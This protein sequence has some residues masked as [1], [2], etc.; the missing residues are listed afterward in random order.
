M[1]RIL[2]PGL[3]S[4]NGKTTAYALNRKAGLSATENWMQRGAQKGRRAGA[5][6]AAK[7][8]RAALLHRYRLAV[9]ICAGVGCST[10]F[11]TRQFELSAT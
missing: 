2:T 11:C 3:P 6:G 7:E 5:D 10:S 9:D 8:C 1:W 4:V